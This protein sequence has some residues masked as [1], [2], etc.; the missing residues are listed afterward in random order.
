MPVFNLSTLMV[1]MLPVL[2]AY[3]GGQSVYSGSYTLP[4]PILLESFDSLTGWSASGGGALSQDSVN[5][6]QG[7]NRLVLSASGVSGQNPIATKVSAFVSDP[8]TWGTVAVNIRQH[9]DGQQVMPYASVGRAGVYSGALN[10]P[11]EE[12]DSTSVIENV[13][14][15]VNV[16]ELANLPIGSGATDLRFRMTGYSPFDETISVDGLYANANGRP[17][18]CITFDDNEDS[19]YDIAYPYM[20]ARGMQGTAYIASGLVGVSDSMNLAEIQALYAANWTIGCDGTPDDSDM[21]LAANP[22]AACTQLQVVQNYLTSNGM[23]R[24]IGHLCYPFG[25]WR[26]GATGVSVAAMTGAGTAT[27]TFGVAATVTPGQTVYGKGVPL[28]TVV[29][30]G[31]VAVTTAVLSNP[32]PVQTFPAKF[33]DESGVFYSDK[34]P[35]HLK[36]NGVLTARTTLGSPVY[37]RFGLEGTQWQR[38]NGNG[39]TGATLAQIIAKVDTAILRGLTIVFYLHR[40]TIEGGSIN[41]STSDFTGLIDYLSTKKDAGILDVM[42]LEQLYARDGAATPP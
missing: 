23:P 31:G 22:A 7:S 18:V 34:L 16:S 35:A 3:V 37:T 24:G 1:G 5:K 17:T 21:T 8:S 9:R 33:I 28:G 20:A 10:P 26:I 41:I 32:I 12:F 27:V 39:V 14:K 36:A 6:I 11:S 30:T 42:T 19:T 29:V 38:L 2:G 25:N 13:W 15:A 4:T 40:I